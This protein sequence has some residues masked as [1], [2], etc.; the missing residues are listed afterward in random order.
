MKLFFGEE[1]FF[2]EKN[3]RV[4]E[5]P[6]GGSNLAYLSFEFGYLRFVLENATLRLLLQ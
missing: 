1:I 4:M 3:L 2:V 6:I 5:T